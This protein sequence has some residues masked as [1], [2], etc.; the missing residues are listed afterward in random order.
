[1]HCCWIE[2]EGG[3]VP[4]NAGGLKECKSGPFLT[5]GKEARTPYLANNLN[6][7]GSRFFPKASR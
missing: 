4:R 6:E 1:M 5:A 7:F 2:D 3:L